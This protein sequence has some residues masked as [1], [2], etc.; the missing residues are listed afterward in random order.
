MLSSNSTDNSRNLATVPNINQ[1]WNNNFRKGYFFITVRIDNSYSKGTQ[2]LI[3]KALRNLQWRSQ[4]IRFDIIYSQ[5]QP[6]V[7]H[8]HYYN[9]DDGCWSWI[10]KN[11][12]QAYKPEGQIIMLQ[13][14]KCSNIRSIQHEMLHALGFA[15]EQSRPDRDEYVKILWQNVIEGREKEFDLDD[16]EMV[17]SLGT[18]Y[19]LDSIMHY[20][21]DAWS[22]NGLPTIQPLNGGE[23]GA[24]THASW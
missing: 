10:G 22:K 6:L 17:D 16:V 12:D 4:V 8:L 14:G 3:V 9:G 5:P 11:P 15:H 24:R 18:D 7:P 20:P 19:D 21:A 1:L 2:E 13:D 23:I